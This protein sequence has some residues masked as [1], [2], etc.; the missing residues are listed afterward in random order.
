[1]RSPC[2]VIQ[3]S[4]APP[5]TRRICVAI[6]SHVLNAP[7]RA[8]F[9]RVRREAPEDHDVWMILSTDDPAAPIAWLNEKDVVRISK[10]DIFR[11]GYPQK[12]REQG[13][14]MAGNLDLVFLEFK[15][16]LPNYS[17]YWFV[18]YDVHWEGIWSVLFEYFR[19]SKAALLAAT[20]Q[21]TDEVPHKLDQLNDPQ[22][23]I[24]TDALLERANIIKAFL[25]LC[26]ISH[27][28]LTALDA[29]YRKG[30]GG[31][32]EFLVPSV[33]VQNG[34]TIEDF[35]GRGRYVKPENVDRFY[36]ARGSAYTH[37]PGTFVFRP[38]QHVLARSNTLWHPVKPGG[39]PLWHPLRFKGSPLKTFEESVKPWIWRAV[40]WLWFATRWRPL[41]VEAAAERPRL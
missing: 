17:H 31:H 2:D 39:V 4:T 12:C 5:G 7:V 11:P 18:E 28:L 22:L 14:T 23:V 24:P 6:V 37:S 13:W 15:R 10:A 30:L 25:P 8:M 26:R 1:M 40:I 9:E 33:A 35:G 41:K 27:E 3:H 38:E 32:Y 16:R 21:H 36:F 34:R 29:A 20:L 19:H